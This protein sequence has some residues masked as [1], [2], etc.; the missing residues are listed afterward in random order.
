VLAFAHVVVAAPDTFL[1]L[2]RI[3]YFSSVVILLLLVV[4]RK[5]HAAVATQSLLRLRASESRKLYISFR[6]R[7]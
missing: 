6:D 2:V 7:Q 5:R 1:S 4:R 3:V